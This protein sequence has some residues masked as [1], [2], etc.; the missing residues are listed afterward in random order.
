MA[1]VRGCHFPDDLL[2]DV[3]NQVWYQPLAVGTV[4]AGLT[5]VATAM[6]GPMLVFTPKR[7][8]RDFEKGKS[9]ANIESGKWVGRA[10]AAFDGVANQQIGNGHRDHAA[11][12]DDGGPAFRVESVD[13]FRAFWSDPYLFGAVAANHAMN[14]VFAMGG[15]PTHALATCAMPHGARRAV[16]E[17]LFQLFSGA[18]SRLDAEGVML[19]SA[20]SSEGPELAAGFFVSAN[21]PRGKLLRKSGLMPGNKL[22]LTK[23]LGADI[24]FAAQM[25]GHA[26]ATD[27]AKAFESM[28]RSNRRAAQILIEH[29]ATAMT[30]VTGIGL[31]GHLCE[32]LEASNMCAHLNF[33]DLPLYP[34]VLNL[35]KAGIASTLL[36]EN[37]A[38]AITLEWMPR[39]DESQ[40]AILFDPQ[41]SG[42]LLAGVPAENEK[43][44][45][46]ALRGGPAPDACVIG[47]VEAGPVG[48]KVIC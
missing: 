47:Q 29:G 37:R 19:A 40:I 23:P 38:T 46:A 43:D 33:A 34:G 36:P 15:T 4:R 11:I 24:V 7:P 6:S 45:L 13:C 30:D 39:S 20:H 44:C 10:R 3:P 42:G 35:A 9:F 16:T 41:T 48:L 31:G 26:R 12:L 2:Y 14:D 17:D 8:T 1:D 21:V 22:I 28:L 18:R 27:V 32:M 25:R 5:S